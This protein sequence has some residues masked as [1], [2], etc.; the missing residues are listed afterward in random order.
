MNFYK[1]IHVINYI[2]IPRNGEIEK[3][4]VK[5]GIIILKLTRLSLNILHSVSPYQNHTPRPRDPISSNSAKHQDFLGNQTSNK[6]SCRVALASHTEC[7]KLRF[8]LS[9]TKEKSG[10]VFVV[11]LLIVLSPLP[12]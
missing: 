6:F 12:V 3:G 1:P 4:N 10:E 2:G 9:W 11:I 7:V 5:S 8:I